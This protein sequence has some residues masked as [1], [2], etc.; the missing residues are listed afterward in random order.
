M[1]GR[2]PFRA[3]PGELTIPGCAAL[4]SRCKRVARNS[5]RH[6]ENPCDDG[7]SSRER[8]LLSRLP[9]LLG[10]FG[11]RR[12]G[13]AAVGDWRLPALRKTP[14]RARNG[15]IGRDDAYGDRALPPTCAITGER[16]SAPRDRTSLAA[17]PP[18]GTQEPSLLRVRWCPDPASV[19]SNHGGQVCRRKSRLV[20]DHPETDSRV[21]VAS[22][23]RELR[24]D[25]MLR[26]VSGIWREPR[27]AAAVC[28][29]CRRGNAERRHCYAGI[30]R[31]GDGAVP[32]VGGLGCPRLDRGPMRPLAAARRT[33]RG[34]RSPDD[35]V[36]LPLE[37]R[38]GRVRRASSRRG[39]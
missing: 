14:A 27:P 30:G 12:M 24:T 10:T 15:L 9:A 32:A 22:S 11:G 17:A 26:L 29:S 25:W 33:Q 18:Y 23:G 36:R 19:Q 38:V 6:L 7:L 1:P 39:R 4:I 20:D 16:R 8:R 28:S 5:P 13:V 21:F 37:L 3:S 35:E 31:R 34:G 2:M